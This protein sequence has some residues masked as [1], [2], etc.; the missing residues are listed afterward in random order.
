M[1]AA[2][3]FAAFILSRLAGAVLIGARMGAGFSQIKYINALI[4]AYP[5]LSRA[6]VGGLSTA[7]QQAAEAGI[8][9]TGISPPNTM[10][11]GNIPGFS[12]L[13]GSKFLVRFG[14]TY[15]TGPPPGPGQTAPTAFSSVL[16][17]SDH[18]PTID[19][20]GD[21][22]LGTV[23]QRII[24]SPES[25]GFMSVANSELSGLFVQYVIQGVN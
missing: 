9:M 19:D 1:P 20:L 6:Q 25:F 15:T 8:E 7:A 2:G 24:D 11:P 5:A 18:I 4:S 22:A 17:R 16:F 14:F 23:A 21:A 3:I 12:S 13:T 10:A